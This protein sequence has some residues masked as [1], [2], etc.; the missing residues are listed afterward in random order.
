M[1]A[2]NSM[3]FIKVADWNAKKY[4]RD[5]RVSRPHQGCDSGSGVMSGSASELVKTAA[6]LVHGVYKRKH[7][8][9]SK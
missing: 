8:F 9:A 7:C 3:K 1:D 2:I 5:L 6:G 4:A